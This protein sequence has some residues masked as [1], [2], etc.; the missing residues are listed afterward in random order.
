MRGNYFIAYHVLYRADKPNLIA[1]LF[2]Y[3]FKHIGYRGLA[4]CAG[5]AEQVQTVRRVSEPFSAYIGICRVGVLYQN[6]IFFTRITLGYNRR[7]TIFHSRSR[8]IVAV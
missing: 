1:G 6:L 4:V 5:Y 8:I 3:A 7:R 2:K